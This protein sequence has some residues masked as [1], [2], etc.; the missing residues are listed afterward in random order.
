MPEIERPDGARIHY[1]DFGTG[2]PVLLLAPDGAS[3]QPE[4][5]EEDV[6]DPLEAL[7]DGFRLICVDQRHSGR[8]S[9]PLGPFSYEQHV[10]DLLAVLDG[11]GVDRT[12]VLGSGLGAAHAL[13]LACQAPE[14]VG[15]VVVQR[16]PGRDAANTLGDFL[17][18]FDEAMRLPRAEGLKGVVAEAEREPRFAR[19]PGAGPFARSLRDD[20]SFRDRI[21][22]LRRE[23]Y[24]AEVVRFRDG[25]WPQGPTW[26]S[27]SD[28]QVA[29]L[30]APL[31]VLPG[32][33]V[34]HPEGAA[35]RLSA[36]A[37][38]AR[39][40]EADHADPDRRDATVR[41]IVAFLTDTPLS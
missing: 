35:K 34:L 32:D 21:L 6:Y 24:I 19:N 28:E 16:P 14:R 7:A 17:G 12:H 27:V 29:Q 4:S 8:G 41:S 40:L 18:Q 36:T 22:A 31:L 23:R 26:F 38:R 9:A 15:G 5:W 33:D 3:G 1:Q 39:L 25:V 37:S 2:V 30:E 11:L 13:R 10:L 20:Q